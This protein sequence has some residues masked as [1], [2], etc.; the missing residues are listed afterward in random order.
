MSHDLKE[1]EESLLS[2]DRDGVVHVGGIASVCTC[3]WVSPYRDNV[4]E[5]FIEHK[6]HRED[7]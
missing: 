7:V 4:A 5:A 1:F 2:R 6:K 3:G